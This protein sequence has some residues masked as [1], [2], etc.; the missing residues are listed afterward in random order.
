MLSRISNKKQGPIE[1]DT[2]FERI[3]TASIGL[4]SRNFER[5]QKKNIKQKRARRV[6]D[7]K[8]KMDANVYRSIMLINKQ[9]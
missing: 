7:K 3:G 1:F 4:T 8:T 2:V 5:K 6:E 9:R